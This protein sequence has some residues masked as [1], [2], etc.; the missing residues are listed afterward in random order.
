MNRNYKFKTQLTIMLTCFLMAFTGLTV[1]AQIAVTVDV[2]TNTTPNLA[3]SYTTLALA[4][5]DLNAVSAMSG[6]V[7]LTLAAGSET[8]P[9]TGLA[10]GSATL[11]PVLSATNTVTLLA[12][13]LVVLNAGV[14]TSTPG[15][16][17][18]DGIF[19]IT[20]ADWITIDGITFTDGNVTNPATMEF[21]L[22]LFKLS[23]S[24]GA[25][26]NT[27]KNCIFNMQRINNA[28]GSAP[29]IEGAVSILMINSISTA[30]TTALA[31]TTAAGSNSNNKFYSN[32]TNGGNYG[33]GLIG[34]AGASPFTA[35]DFNNDIGGTSLATGN[36]ILNYGGG[37]AANPAAAI[38]TLAQYGINISYNTVNNNNGSGVNHAT[39][40]RGIYLNTAVSASATISNN[41]VTVLSGAITSAL[42]AIENASG[43]TAASNTITINNNTITGCS[44]LTAT[45]GT[46][47][48]VLNTASPATS[49]ISGNTV[50]GTIMGTSGVASVCIFQG[51][52][53]SGGAV[54]T[55]I[56][57][58]TISG[59]VIY[60]Q[61]GTMYCLRAGT[62]MLNIFGNIIYANTIPLNAGTLAGIVHGIYDL[63]SPTL[64][65]ITNNTIYNQSVTGST[66]STTS[67]ISGIYLNTTASS[68]KSWSGNTI[69]GFSYSNSSTGAAS[70]Y[71]IYSASGATINILKNKI[72]DLSAA[73]AG[74]IVSGIYISSGT[75]VNVYNNLISDLRTPSANAANPLNGINVIGGTTVNAFYN[76]VMLSGSSTGA[77]FG[78][79]AISASTTPTLTLRNNIFINNSGFMGAGL[80][81]AYRR[82]TAT[83]TSYAAASN[84]NLFYAGTPS[85]SN[86]IFTDGTTPQQTI[87]GYKAAVTPRDANSF[88][89]EVAFTYGT[90]GSFFIS[91]TGSS[92]D[93]LRPVAGITTQVESGGS[94]ISSPLITDD[95]SGLTRAGN[96]GYIGTGT[97]PDL[98]AYEFEGISPAPI[99][100]FTSAT[101]TLA[102]SLCTKA[103]RAIV[104]DITT[105]TGTI[106]GAILNYFHNGVAQT[107]ITMTNTAGS[108]W[109][110][111]MLAPTIGN[112]NVAWS[113]TATNSL[114]LNTTYTGTIYSD[115]PTTGVT[116]SASASLT[117]VC[118]GSPTVLSVLFSSTATP[119][120]TTPPAVSNPTTDEDLGNITI[121]KGA[122]TILNNSSVI[123]SLTGTIGLATGTAGS[124]SDFSSFG[125]YNINAGQTYNFSISTLQA[126]TAYGNAVGIYIDYNR[127]GLFTD[128]GEAVYVS[129]TTTLGAH[130]ETGSFIVPATASIGSTRM[131]I[132][133][134]EDP[135][136]GPNM[137]V[138]WGEYE[139]YTLSIQPS[140]T[141]SW[142]DG[143]STVGITNPLTVSPTT[144]TTYTATAILSGCPI[145]SNS[146]AISVLPLPTAPTATNSIQCGTQIPLASV[147]S[148]AG[149]DGTGTFNWYA[150]ATGGLALQSS[151][152][153][154]YGSSIAATT[155]LYVSESGVNTCESARTPVTITVGSPPALTL[156]SATI[157]ICTGATS[158]VI[159]VTSTVADFDSYVWAPATDV[160]G[161]EISGWTFNPSAT[162]TYTLT[163]G[164]SGTGCANTTTIIVTVNEL[165]LITS[166]TTSVEPLCAGD[167]TTLTAVSIPAVSGTATIG[168]GV[169]S[170]TTYDNPFFSNW[171]HTQEQILVKGSELAA[172]GL[173]AGNLT[174][175]GI[176]VT[177]GTTNM[178]DF[179]L[180]IQNTALNAL[181][182]LTTSGFTTVYTNV[183]GVTP[184]IDTN[185]ITFS[186]PFNWDGSSNI[187]LKFCWGNSGTT[188]TQS[189]TVKADVTSY[190]SSLN[191]HNTTA[192][193][194][195]SIC[196]GSTLYLSYSKRPQF[197]FG[198]QVGANLTS[199]LNWLWSPSTGL[200]GTTTNVVTAGPTSTLLYTVTATNPSTTCSS[201]QTV[202]VTVNPKPTAPVSGNITQCGTST[203]IPAVNYVTELNG[204]TTPT[205][206]WYS[207]ATGGTTV[208]STT[209][210]TV[211]PT[212]VLGVNTFYVTVTNPTTGCESDRTPVT[213]TVNTPP[214]F[215]LSS[216]STSICSGLSSSA[217]TIASGALDYDTYSWSP[218]ANV[219]GNS[220]SGWIFNPT[221]TL[222]YTLTAFN[223]V[224]G[225]I[226]T[227]TVVVTVNPLPSAVTIAPAGPMS[228]CNNAIQNLTASGGSFNNVSILNENFNGATNTWTT[229]NNS[230]GGTPASAAWTLTADGYVYTT[231]GTW[232]SN[233]NSQFYLTNS[234]AQG[235]AGTTSTLLESPSFSTVGFSSANL[236]FYHFLYNPSLANVEYTVNGTTWTIIQA[237]TTTQG[238]SGAFVQA[239]LVLPAGALNQAS[240]KIRFK[241]E[242]SWGYFWGIDNVSISGTM[243]QAITWS[244]VTNLYS[245]AAATTA[246]TGAASPTVYFKSNTSGGPVTY[247]ATSTSALTCTSA[248]TVNL[249][250][251]PAST[252]TQSITVCA[253]DSV[254]VGG[255]TYTTTGT[256]IDVIT[257]GAATGCDS[258]VTTNLTVS[259]AVTST[260]TLIVCA[261]VTVTVGGNSHSATGTYV[262]VIIAGSA[263]GCDSTVTTDLTVRPAVTGAQTLTVCAGVSVTV[264]ANTHT[265][266]GIYTDVVLGG[267]YTGC[268]ST[269][270]TD[271]T[272]RPAVTSSQ[273]LTLCSGGSITVGGNT[274]TSTGI[275]TDVVTGGASTGCDST[276]TSDLTILPAA[277]SSTSIT[278][279]AGGSVTI[280]GNTHNTTG[281]FTD[282][283]PFGAVNGCDSTVV[284]NLTVVSPI[285]VSTSVVGNIITANSA[286]ATYQ[287]LDC[288]NGNAII[289][290]ETGQS[291]TAL[292]SG[293]YA[294]II[295]EA[296]ICSDTSTCVNIIVTGI[297]SNGSQF[298]TISPNPTSGLFTLTIE[299][300]NSDEVVI[301]IVDIQGKVVY[302]ELDKNISATYTKQINLTDLSKGIYFVKLNVG[303]DLKVEKLIVQ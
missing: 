10:I 95:Y 261:G 215:S 191:A 146:V 54:N 46:F 131:R 60:N 230:T 22:A 19:K 252:K 223:S 269:V 127:N 21:G 197:I 250:V 218:S 157:S 42:T 244:P 87:A 196:S 202:N 171:S 231:Y 81:V 268:D 79:S 259:P 29:M 53:Q 28:S 134:N 253:G 113:V 302:N 240:V 210:K 14:G 179:A 236:N 283:I 292:V 296:G 156:S 33:M 16:A 299:N 285:D 277:T 71:G 121:T 159:T 155:T 278:V 164:N 112:D 55:T 161:T 219:S 208:L 5:S 39:T 204:Y 103:D 201:S 3:A 194:G 133:V 65:T 90:P 293:N 105:S 62:T 12:Q 52:Y 109:T 11:N 217:I 89:G 102:P 249:T 49:A 224:S 183:S 154:T 141:Y 149:V 256:F 251:L 137:A 107:P 192:T 271:L 151:T 143:T 276:V 94:N 128:A 41:T 263:S 298:I 242:D 63:S 211:S 281:V 74:S 150:N 158:S 212:L 206:N 186:T 265:T 294:V 76:T 190:V 31:P 50:T 106:T 83:L 273:T 116:A 254:T 126:A 239:S 130:T 88:T 58:N 187:L 80:A 267:S 257:A 101:P 67:I 291:F 226:N 297:S 73:G 182:T 17:A 173:V 78:S 120:Y 184:I 160:S 30:A 247:T 108:S 180:G 64:E 86:L 43:S 199:T 147:A 284:T 264:G 99:I 72:V 26:N 124:Y 188:A 207:A 70:V 125:P 200:S 303:S 241:F 234:D 289:A 189:N 20:G 168:A 209:D 232:H 48:G 177:A 169:S 213:I 279:C 24:D 243:Q 35:C 69:Y 238:T 40:L 1:Q 181:S 91:L 282:V 45:T 162:T 148:A 136:T 170:A 9:A 287:W 75:T 178:P 37:A 205:F 237:Y 97:N 32:I 195:S 56:N 44:Y 270:T 246:Y 185:T 227:V 262:D 104:V 216:A 163:A 166:V 92:S 198:G 165:P 286:T 266:T 139:E 61:G 152:A 167:S 222:T 245:D 290:G 85:A 172:A 118:N 274:H 258:T 255:N 27:I 138:S 6:P 57:N 132:V 82:S 301:T 34:Y 15:T 84:N 275:Y 225:C 203:P 272:V 100:V 23:L 119:A 2:P 280:A 129:S 300:A 142:S 98:G 175:L 110:G 221:T 233:D 59:N 117:T 38:R 115:E 51:L 4:L 122:A 220:T 111:T 145:V 260:Q 114:G 13:G 229:I 144:N 140:A 176:V 193:S 174:S 68:V 153:T 66:T 93:F 248:A 8:A 77:L 47:T 7:T 18:P 214:V 235:S 288:D 36:N 135:V 96:A 295:T 123:N 228:I 25:Q